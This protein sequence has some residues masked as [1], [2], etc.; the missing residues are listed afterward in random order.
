MDY[1][2]L[3]KSAL[4]EVG[5]NAYDSE[6]DPA[7]TVSLVTGAVME[8]VEANHPGQVV[9]LVSAVEEGDVNLE[10]Q[11]EAWVEGYEEFLEDQRRLK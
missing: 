9:G 5:S 4:L 3:V 2:E 6:S 8:W 7:E 1:S 11:V 10:E